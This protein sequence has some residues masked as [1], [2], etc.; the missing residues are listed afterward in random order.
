MDGLLRKFY[1]AYYYAS[2]MALVLLG[3]YGLD[4]LQN[5]AVRHFSDVPPRP[6]CEP[7][8]DLGGDPVPPAVPVSDSDSET[9]SSP[10]SSNFL[11]PFCPA[12]SL[13]RLY[14]IVP[15][16]NRH[17]I[18]I[19]YPLP[20]QYPHWRSKPTN[21][22][23]HLL[24]HEA[25]GSILAHLKARGLATGCSVEGDDAT[26]STHSLFTVSFTLSENGVLRWTECV[27]AVYLYLG[28]LRSH[29]ETE[30][31]LPLRI[32]EELREVS[33][34]SY[35]FAEETHAGD[36][37]TDL[38]ETIVPKRIAPPQDRLLD[39][40]TRMFE[41]RP[42]LVKDILENFLSPSNSRVDLM[43]TVF[44]RS[45]D[46][47]EIENDDKKKDNNRDVDDDDDDD[48]DNSK[49]MT[50]N[51]T[52][53]CCSCDDPS[54][55]PPPTAFDLMKAM[56]V[57]RDNAGYAPSAMPFTP[58]QDGAPP[59]QMEP[60][61][62]TKFW[63][64]A[65]HPDTLVRWEGMREPATRRSKEATEAV[66]RAGLA[67]PPKNNFVPTE[68][69]L[70]ALPP[71]DDDHPLVSSS[72][73][74]C[75]AVGK[76]KTWFAATVQRYNSIK[77]QIL[78]FFEDEDE[79]WYTLDFN[80]VEAKSMKLNNGYEGTLN[81]GK[82]KFRIVALAMN[83]A[84]PIRKYE[85]DTDDHVEDGTAFPPVPPATPASRLPKKI[86][87]NKVRRA[88]DHITFRFFLIKTAPN[89]IYLFL[90]CDSSISRS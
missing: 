72:L 47:E 61:F 54:A 56:N 4:D 41:W 82:V 19:I 55:P 1:G 17:V 53:L 32:Y 18:T 60:T 10:S 42:D 65:I 34:M 15:V 49:N 48:D 63:C 66:E 28:M 46:Y 12:R 27:D 25:A 75:I 29:F 67:L 86:V 80:S 77:N 85:D 84:G 22:L 50:N 21:V 31:T 64:H 37:V 8:H 81:G 78:L 3:G 9:D 35:K 57:W 23:A 74:L 24:G 90:D 40:E 89:T 14:R 69:G 59:P 7:P 68:F 88:I 20:P 76:K 6:K 26:S 62:G 44:G 83:N 87:N 73:K 16:D 38:V 5:M 70:R 52:V 2:N 71:D 30:G 79:K 13:R 51:E 39:A 43:S 45:N 36:F 11:P 33:E 58:S